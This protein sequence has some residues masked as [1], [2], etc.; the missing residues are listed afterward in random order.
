MTFGGEVFHKACSALSPHEDWG[1]GG[2]A[3]NEPWTDIGLFFDWLSDRGFSDLEKKLLLAETP[4][5]NLSTNHGPLF[6]VKDFIERNSQPHAPILASG[7]II[8]ASNPNGDD[9]VVRRSDS[10]A[11]WLR[12]A[13]TGGKSHKEIRELFVATHQ[14]LGELLRDAQYHWESVSKDWY[15]AKNSQETSINSRDS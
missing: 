15:E 8:V 5:I 4:R 1:P 13:M 9:I 6:G 3:P 10:S 7:F 11:G 2:L 12:M 14:S